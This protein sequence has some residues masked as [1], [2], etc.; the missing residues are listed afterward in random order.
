MDNEVITK[1]YLRFNFKKQIP[2]PYNT[3]SKNAYP[4]SLQLRINK[5][6]KIRS[7]SKKEF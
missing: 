7:S 4:F 6:L 5:P 3:E 2:V 1:F